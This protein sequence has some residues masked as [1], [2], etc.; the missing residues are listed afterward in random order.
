MD[1]LYSGDFV[2]ALSSEAVALYR[3]L[4][5]AP[6]HLGGLLQQVFGLCCNALGLGNELLARRDHHRRHPPRR[7]VG[8]GQKTTVI[9][10]LQLAGVLLIAASGL[11]ACA[12][13]Q[14]PVGEPHGAVVAPDGSAAKQSPAEEGS[15]EER[16][17]PLEPFNQAMLTFNR[18]ADDWVLHPVAAKWAYVMPQPA[19]ASV[20]RFFKNVGVIPRF[21]NDLFQLQFTQGGTEV[22]RFGINSTVGVAGLF[23]PADK[24]FGLKQEDNDFGLTLAKYGVG[25]G[26][27][28]VLPLLGPSTVRDALGRFADGAMNPVN[29]VVAGAL[30]YEAAATAVAAVNARSENLGTFDDVDRYSIDLY[31][32]VQDAYLQQRKQKEN[33]VRA[34]LLPAPGSASDD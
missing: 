1:F 25:E 19:R 24:W 16:A 11:T 15:S 12:S 14:N 9:R 31:G 28:I 18:K 8:W 27:Y 2:H 17:D 6:H 13:G 20:G 23:D 22:A 10:K 26:P 30:L 4:G 32:A 3:H 33:K 34:G 21:A 7:L 29:Y 5:P